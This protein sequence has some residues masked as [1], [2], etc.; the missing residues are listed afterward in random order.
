M[1]LL[2]LYIKDYWKLVLLQALQV[3]LGNVL[4][5]SLGT[6]ASTHR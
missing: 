3:R 6:L 1:N 2:I 4:M 5:C